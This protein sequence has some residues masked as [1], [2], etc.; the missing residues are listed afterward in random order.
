MNLAYGTGHNGKLTFPCLIIELLSSFFPVR[1]LVPPSDVSSYIERT[2]VSDTLLISQA[3]GDGVTHA[4][5]KFGENKW[6]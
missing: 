6:T 5:S 1:T 4:V 3:R 2:L